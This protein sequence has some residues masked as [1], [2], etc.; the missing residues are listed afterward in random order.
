MSTVRL[1]TARRVQLKQTLAFLLGST[2][3]ASAF[4]HS[5]SASAQVSKSEVKIEKRKRVDP[6]WNDPLDGEEPKPQDSLPTQS[7]SDKVKSGWRHRKGTELKYRFK[8]SFDSFANEREQAQFFGFVAETKSKLQLLESLWFDVEG[9]LEVVSGYAQSQFGDNVGNSGVFLREAALSYEPVSSDQYRMTLSAGAINQ[10]ALN[11]R[12]LIERQPF[13]GAKAALGFGP[14]SAEVKLWAQ[15]AIPT[16]RTL[17]T[18]TVDVEPI[19]TFESQTLEFNFEPDPCDQTCLIRGTKLFATR[20]AYRNLPSQV[21]F[22]SSLYGN[23]LTNPNPTPNN[24]R[25]RYAFD[26]YG[27]GGEVAVRTTSRLDLVAGGY[28][29]QNLAAPEDRRTGQMSLL[30]LH[31]SLPNEVLL[32]TTGAYYFTESDVAPAFYSAPIFGH[33]NREGYSGLVR[34]EFKRQM[35]AIEGAFVDA[36][37]INPSPGFA[38]TRQQTV[39]VRF[40]TLYE[41]L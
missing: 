11:M 26:G 21:A 29:M 6:Y 10:A 24:S 3:S 16:S 32:K 18:R 25:F 30:A 14:K 36:G 27:L 8:S 33:M 34:A 9:A 22:Q 4:I 31:L 41:I 28:L 40:E 7:L 19:P 39:Y 13:P 15:Y 2:L 5:D 38:Q 12:T 23:T 35:F 20:W 17:S 1:K 37:L